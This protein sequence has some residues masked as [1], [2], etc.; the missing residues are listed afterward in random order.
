MKVRVFQN[1]KE[2]A[3]LGAA[4]CPWAWEWTE[5]GRRVAQ[6]LGSKEDA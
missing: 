4:R 1:S 3:R 5:Y 2:K 6:T